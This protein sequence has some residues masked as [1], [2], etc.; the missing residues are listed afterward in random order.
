MHLT[1]LD[2]LLW[3]AGFCGH[4]VLLAVLFLRRQ[5]RAFPMFTA[6]ITWNVLR[7]IWLYQTMHHRPQSTYF[8]EY[9]IFAALDTLLEV[10]VICDLAART[11]GPSGKWEGKALARFVLI[12]AGS[13]VVAAALIALSTPPH[14]SW[15][16]VLVIK[17]SLFSATWMS[18]LFAGMLFLSVTAGLPWNTHVAKIAQGLGAYSLFDMLVEAGHSYFGAKWG[19]T[20]YADLSHLRIEAYL[21]CLIYWIVSLWSEAPEACGMTPEMREQLFTLLNR[22]EYDLRKL[23]S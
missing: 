23:R 22:V 19:S 7:T 9:W 10:G 1:R 8:A 11:F 20:L 21:C 18:E 3:T 12:F 15:T 14:W 16:Q 17:G 6:L 5:F 4:L 2:L 13:A